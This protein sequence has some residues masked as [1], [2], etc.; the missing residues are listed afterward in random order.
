MLYTIEAWRIT[1][2][3]EENQAKFGVSFN[4]VSQNLHPKRKQRA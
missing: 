2:I 3:L 4:L 1:Q